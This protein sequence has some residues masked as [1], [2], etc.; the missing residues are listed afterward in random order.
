MKS[1]SRSLNVMLS[2]A[3]TDTSLPEY[4]KPSDPGQVLALPFARTGQM[5]QYSIES[6]HWRH[7]LKTVGFSQAAAENPTSRHT[8]WAEPN[9]HRNR[10]CQGQQQLRERAQRDFDVSD[11]E[12]SCHLSSWAGHHCALLTLIWTCLPSIKGGQFFTHRGVR[13]T[14]PLL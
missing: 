14:V 4:P 2:S 8:A 11:C 3:R 13:T 7:I 1:E 10:F 6:F 12:M 5:H 9:S